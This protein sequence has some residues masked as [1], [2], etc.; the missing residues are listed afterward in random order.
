MIL[1]LHPTKTTWEMKM[2]FKIAYCNPMCIVYI[3]HYVDFYQFSQHLLMINSF[4]NVVL[5]YLG[6]MLVFFFFDF[7]NIGNMISF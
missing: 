4:E 2:R 5:H 6:L 3:R 7:L 1:D